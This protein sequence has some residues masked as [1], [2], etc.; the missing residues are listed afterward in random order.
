[1][2]AQSMCLSFITTSFLFNIILLPSRKVIYPL[3]GIVVFTFYLYF[4]TIYITFFMSYT[5]IKG[6]W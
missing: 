1:M 5:F 6:I 4:C 2:N 3:L